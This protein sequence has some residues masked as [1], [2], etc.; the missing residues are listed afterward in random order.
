[1]TGILV[2]DKTFLHRKWTSYFFCEFYV[3][4]FTSLGC[5]LRIVFYLPFI[6]NVI[7]NNLSFCFWL[8]ILSFYI[9]LSFLD[10]SLSCRYRFCLEDQQNYMRGYSYE[11]NMIVL[12]DHLSRFVLVWKRKWVKFI[13]TSI[14]STVTEVPVYRPGWHETNVSLLVLFGPR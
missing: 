4:D 12:E 9:C 14:S 3:S 6:T 11:R 10:Y 2:S 13:T 8:L 5:S 7:C 1:M